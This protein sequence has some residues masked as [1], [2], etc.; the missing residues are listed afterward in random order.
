MKCVIPC[1]GE[2]SRM[3]YVPKH[4]V[5]INGKPL[6]HHVIDSWKDRVD[7]FVFVIR[8]SMTYIWELLPENAAIVFQDEPKGLADAVLQAERCTTG[9]FIVALGDCLHRGKF[10]SI[11]ACLGIGVW[12]TADLAEVNKS[13]LV[14]TEGGRVEKLTEKPNLLRIPKGHARNCGMGTYFLDTR[15]FEYIRRY[16]GPTGG[17]DFTHVLQDMVNNGEKIEPAWFQGTYVNVGSP[18]DLK[19]AERILQ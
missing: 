1:A 18:D 19:K 14:Y 3:S 15:I 5:T 12:R 17:G 8:R 7:S 13:Y 10:R 16:E 9:Q 6:L 11:P 2:S 4:L